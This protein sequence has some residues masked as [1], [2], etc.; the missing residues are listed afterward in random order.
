[1]KILTRRL[2]AAWIAL[3]VAGCSSATPT[4]QAA[5][6]TASPAIT[7]VATAPLPSPVASPAASPTPTPL[8]SPPAAVRGVDWQWRPVWFENPL[9]LTPSL[10]GVIFTGN[11]FLAWGANA[12]GSATMTSSGDLRSWQEGDTGLFRGVRIIGMAYA[13]AGIV[14]LGVDKAGVVH[15]WRSVDG[16]TWKAGPARTGIDGTVR[17]L[18]SFSGGLYYAAGTATGSCDVTIWTSYDGLS[19]KPSE[20]LNEA[21]GTCVIG[22]GD[23]PILREGLVY[24]AVPGVGNASWTSTDRVHWAFH[25]QPSMAGTIT[26]LAATR[27][28]YVA[29]GDT[30]DG[31]AAVW[32][33][34]D[35]VTWTAA[36]DQAAL[37]GATIADVRAL[38]DGS[39]VA[40]G[41]DP[42]NP[43][44]SWSS[45]D[46]LA[47]V[48]GPAPVSTD[49]S[50]P[51]R[52]DHPLGWVLASDG[53][54]S[55]NPS[56]LL[57][58]VAGG[59]RAMV[60]PPIPPDP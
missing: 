28:G 13:P 8:P 53:H 33:S 47:W 40:V 48:R 51:G 46:G 39:L 21:R 22:P 30:G 37:H 17:T 32:L 41:S 6:R 59:W 11:G 54:A 42:S 1:M 16:I 56:E 24:D 34:P 35:G 29:V 43:F 20:T 23:G 58:A 55:S 60:S 31:S 49:G 10:D 9:G 5:G 14:A 26:G 7:A 19:W 36:P 12:G 50:T 45:T 2:V 44:V 18:V 57:I 25:P 15:A 3:V 52:P 27:A 4:S 38:D